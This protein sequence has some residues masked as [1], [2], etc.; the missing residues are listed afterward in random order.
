LAELSGGHQDKR[1]LLDLTFVERMY[2]VLVRIQIRYV[3]SAVRE[4]RV[5]ITRASSILGLVVL[6]GCAGYTPG[7][8]SY[9]DQRV[10][11]MCAKD[12]GVTIY[13]RIP[14][15]KAQFEKL[16]RV[17]GHAAIP[18]RTDA[19]ADDLVFWDE[20]STDIRDA[21]PRVWRSEQIVRRRSDEKIVARI[22]RYSRVGGDMPTGLAH[23]SSLGC[24][25]EEQIFAQQEKIFAI[26][27]PSR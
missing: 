24:P 11:D 21:N 18:P 14:I 19:K 8:K 2:R 5:I 15:P 4:E 22:V 26:S 23:S 16:P 17:G 13:E 10:N 20:F 12:G 3:E 1:T 9:W 7:A 27:D 6:Y 25:E